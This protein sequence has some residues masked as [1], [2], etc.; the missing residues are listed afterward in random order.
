MGGDEKQAADAVPLPHGMTELPNGMTERLEL[1][2]CHAFWGEPSAA[3]HEKCRTQ[4][5]AF[6]SPMH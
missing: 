3:N 6:A 1:Q 4:L 5:F 2:V